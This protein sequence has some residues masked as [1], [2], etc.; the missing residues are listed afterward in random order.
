MPVTGVAAPLLVVLTGPTGSGKSDFAVSLAQRLGAHVP[1]EIVSVDSAQVY[2]GMDIGTAKPGPA[3]R[4]QLPHHLID[5]RDPTQGYSA[6]E[7][8]ADA[9]AAIAAVHARGALPLLVGG[10]MLYLHA[11]RAGL[12]PLPKAS[13]EIRSQIDA[14]AAAH[15][16]S[17]VHAQLARVDRAAAARIAPQ[18]AQRLQRAL[19][20]YRLTGVPMSDWQARAQAG[21]EQYR[22]L[23]YALS[24]LSRQRLREQLQARFAA[25][26]RGGLLEEVRTL[27]ARGDLTPR[28]PAMRA[29][30][31]R[32]LWS[33]CAGEFSLEQASAAAVTATAQLA[34]RQ[35]TWLRREREITTLAGDGVGDME[36][37][38]TRICEAARA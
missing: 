11:L 16:W 2:R 14:L 37:V 36:A 26:L 5:I 20:V 1:V 23:R 34:K 12:A 30:G 19:E 28:H 29:V 4:Q 21:P 35:M 18:D 17:A 7:F 15:G 27:Y 24:P 8:V 13:P 6:G 3:I 10:T 31:Y 22:W 25:M 38:L 9:R 32:Q 33:Y